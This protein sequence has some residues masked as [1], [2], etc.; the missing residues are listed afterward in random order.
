M[1]AYYSALGGRG[2]YPYTLIMDENGIVLEVFVS[3]LEYE[4][5]QRVVDARLAESH[6]VFVKTQLLFSKLCVM[7]TGTVFHTRKEFS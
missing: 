7:V 3:S 1:G 4:D 2:A 6:P 5:L